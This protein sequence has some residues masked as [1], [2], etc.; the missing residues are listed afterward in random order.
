M[1]HSP[2][3]TCED[4]RSLSTEDTWALAH[5][6]QEL[7][8]W[9]EWQE[10]LQDGASADDD[11]VLLSFDF[12]ALADGAPRCAHAL[13]SEPESF[14]ALLRDEFKGRKAR[15]QVR[16]R[17]MIAGL[18]GS[19]AWALHS[20][21]SKSAGCSSGLLEV[22][23]KVVALQ[24]AQPRVWSRLVRCTNAF[25]CEEGQ[26]SFL[27]Q[28][29]SAATRCPRCGCTLVED[30]RA[31]VMYQIRHMCVCFETNSGLTKTLIVRLD[32]S[33]SRFE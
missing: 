31:R 28:E 19:P 30:C 33:T 11:R 32:V 18:H 1:Q 4:F 9:Q 15:L 12:L 6:Q 26:G 22:M 17:N 23:A 7:A 16:P 29:E 8:D 2:E 14:L 13:L 3:R 24:Q 10:L 5:L 20:P 25:C 21:W 27:I